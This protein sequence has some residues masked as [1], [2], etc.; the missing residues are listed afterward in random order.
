MLSKYINTFFFWFSSCRVSTCLQSPGWQQEKMMN[1]SW[2]YHTCRHTIFLPLLDDLSS[3]FPFKVYDKS[4]HSA[5]FNAEISIISLV[6]VYSSNMI[7]TI[8]SV[9]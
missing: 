4:I 2:G 6:I 9:L 7:S 1:F 3:S 5:L 8:E